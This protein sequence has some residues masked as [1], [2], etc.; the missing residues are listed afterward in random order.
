MPVTLWRRLRRVVKWTGTVVVLLLVAGASYQACSVRQ[1]AGRFPPPGRLVDIGGRRLHLLCIGDGEPTVLFEPSGFGSAVSSTAARVE[2]SR[3]ARV[4]SY[5]RAGTGWSD[6]G[7]SILSAGQLVDDLERLLD[8]AGLHPPYI[9]VASSIGGLTAELFARR[10]PDWIR[11]L[12]FLDAANSVGLDDVLPRVNWASTQAV[13]LTRA[14]AWFGLIRAWDPFGLRREGSREAIARLYRV[15]PMATLCGIVRGARQSAEE[16]HAATPLSSTV[17]LTVL[18][19]ASQEQ[20]LPLGLRFLAPSMD[21][22]REL[23]REFA[24]RSS[25][26]AWRVVPGSTHLI[27]NSQPHAVATAVL[28]MMSS[29]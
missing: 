28:E 16:F 27:G 4:C 1:E 6:P 23:Q 3:R 8:Q 12:V 9:V 2:I 5:D 19:A 22:H 29:S 21:R 11:G 24:Q 15:E 26:G 18:T 25:R 13:C 17:P 20:L 10:H 7:P 14:A